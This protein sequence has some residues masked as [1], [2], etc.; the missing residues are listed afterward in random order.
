MFGVRLTTQPSINVQ[1]MASTVSAHHP[2]KRSTTHNQNANDQK[3]QRRSQHRVPPKRSVSSLSAI[4]LERKRANDREAQRLI[5][6]RTKDRIDGLE[7]Q[8]T[9]LR[10]E[11]ERLGRCLR[12]R[13]IGEPES[14]PKRSNLEAGSTS[15]NC[16]QVPNSI[17]GREMPS[18][19]DSS[20]YCLSTE[21]VVFEILADKNRSSG[22][23][24]RGS[25]SR[26][27]SNSA[28]FIH[29]EFSRTFVSCL[30]TT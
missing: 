18:Q 23:Y 15:W 3:R 19:G 2:S 22:I 20:A 4:Q 28:R 8:I 30:V 5:R 14:F 1:I 12:Q 13:S 27:F 21:A 6:Q 7:K 24:S 29:I 17:R 11:N 10:K 16:P 9:D 25:T 26:V